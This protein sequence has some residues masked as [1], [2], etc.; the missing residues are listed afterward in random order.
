MNKIASSYS[1]RHICILLQK[2]TGRHS[3]TSLK[4]PLDFTFIS[5]NKDLYEDDSYSLGFWHIKKKRKV[6]SNSFYFKVELSCI[7]SDDT[8]LLLW[9]NVIGFNYSLFYDIQF[10][11]D[12]I[13][14]CLPFMSLSPSM[15]LLLYLSNDTL[16]IDW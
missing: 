4:L 16:W 9:P 5:Y 6:F 1:Y 12:I 14:L 10:Y 2:S 7:L 3:E 15:C 13:H 8:F 11:R